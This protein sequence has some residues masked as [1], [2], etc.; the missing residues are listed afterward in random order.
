MDKE[1]VEQ[2]VKELDTFQEA[3]AGTLSG[4]TDPAVQRYLYAFTV[5]VGRVREILSDSPKVA[6]EPGIL[7]FYR[8]RTQR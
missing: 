1:K 2:I 3:A 6:A 5:L 8:E 4:G 7:A